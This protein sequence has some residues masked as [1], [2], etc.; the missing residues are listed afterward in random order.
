M[1]ESIVTKLQ[2][3]A[4]DFEEL[5]TSD[6]SCIYLLKNQPVLICRVVREYIPI[7]E[8]QKV[9]LAMSPIIVERGIK[10]LVFDKRVLSAFHQPSM[11]WYFLVWKAD[12][13]EKRLHTYRKLLPEGTW[14]RRAVEAGRA[15]I[16]GNNPNHI[17]DQLDIVYSESLQEAIEE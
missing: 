11:E 7:E 13:Y 2:Q 16:I 12:M 5:Y 3:L 4:Y 1:R 14:F 15:Q 10:K 8:F 17:I 9:F 6:Y